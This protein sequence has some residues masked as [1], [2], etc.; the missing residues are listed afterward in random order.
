MPPGHD[1]LDPPGH[2]T[3]RAIFGPWLTVTDRS[4]GTLGGKRRWKDV[5]AR[6]A[7]IP[8]WLAAWRPGRRSPQPVR[9]AADR[10]EKEAGDG[11]EQ[12][13]NTE[14]SSEFEER[15]LAPGDLLPQCTARCYRSLRH[16]WR[17]RAIRRQLRRAHRSSTPRTSTRRP[18]IMDLAQQLAIVHRS[19]SRD[20][21]L[22]RTAPAPDS[23]PPSPN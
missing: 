23:A 3:T 6:L 21:C 9:A 4:R 17:R 11:R 22:A 20:C 16:C 2:G 18:P 7:E 14:P 13:R 19:A 5:V 8:A 12:P 15:E 10:E 1:P